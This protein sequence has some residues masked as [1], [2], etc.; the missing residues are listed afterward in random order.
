MASEPPGCNKSALHAVAEA[1]G[2]RRQPTSAGSSEATSSTAIVQLKT[3]SRRGRSSTR[4][5]SRPS[6]V[7]KVVEI[8]DITT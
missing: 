1:A 8:T 2:I 7:Q 6:T 5:A 4:R 3:R